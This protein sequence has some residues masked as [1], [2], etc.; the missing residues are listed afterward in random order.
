MKNITK[1]L[2]LG[3]L[4]CLLSA[5]SLLSADKVTTQEQ[6]QESTLNGKGYLKISLR[7]TGLVNTEYLFVGENGYYFDAKGKL[8]NGRDASFT[9]SATWESSNPEVLVS[10]GEG[11]FKALKDGTATVK[12]TYG[13]F[14]DSYEVTVRTYATFKALLDPENEYR[15]TKTYN[16]PIK[17]EPLNAFV[18][19]SQSGDGEVEFLDE[20]KFTAKKA[21]SVDVSAKVFISQDGRTKS[22]DFTLNVVENDTPYF[23]FNDVVQESASIDIAVN[24]YDN[25]ASLLSDINLKAFKGNNDEEITTINVKEGNCNTKVLGEYNL[26]LVAQNND[27][28]STFNLKVNII[29]REEVT[30]NL[31]TISPEIIAFNYELDS[32]RKIVSFTVKLSLP[33]T[34]EKY[35]GEFKIKVD[36]KAKRP[37]GYEFYLDKTFT[38]YFER[39]DKKQFDFSFDVI[40]ETYTIKEDGGIV[41]VTKSI[42]F[43]GN[44]HNY[45]TYP[46]S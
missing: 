3:I 15:T 44:G 19:Y 26:V 27:T 29:E 46:Q 45:I 17:I 37:N 24:K 11:G 5:C 43:T 23:K 8:D 25:F 28:Q 13:E 21:G 7:T 35:S 30:T 36:V 20:H 40:S 2:F 33:D 32:T 16:L 34:Y 1:V 39:T 12:A 41:A 38:S 4:S 42:T 22:F 31:G 14:T 10:T 6:Q 18:I 9:Y